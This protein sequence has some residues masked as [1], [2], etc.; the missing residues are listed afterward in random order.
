MDLTLLTSLIIGRYG[1]VR[2]VSPANRTLGACLGAGLDRSTIAVRLEHLGWA[3][4]DADIAGLTPLQ[5]DIQR[6]R[7]LG[8]VILALGG[9]F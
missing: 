2:A 3:E 8:I 9:G 5:I 1:E 7:S 6:E 4:G